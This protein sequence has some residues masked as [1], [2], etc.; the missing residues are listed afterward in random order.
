MIQFHSYLK[1]VYKV[2]TTEIVHDWISNTDD[3]R[4]ILRRLDYAYGFDIIEGN[5]TKINPNDDNPNGILR[6]LKR[7]QAR[8]NNNPEIDYFVKRVEETCETIKKLHCLFLVASYEQF[9]QDTNTFL[10]RFYSQINDPAKGQTC[11]LSGPKPFFRIRGLEHIESS[12]DKRIEFFHVPFDKRYLMGTYRYSIPGYPSL[13]CSSS[14]YCACEEFGCKDI[15]KCGY[16]AYRIAQPIRVLDLRWRFNDSKL[17]QSE[18]P[19]LVKH[20]LLRLPIIIACGMQ[21][22]VTSAKFVPEYIFSQQVFQWLMSQM[23]H[24]EKLNTTMGVLYTSTKENLWQE[25]CKRNNADAMTNYALLAFTSVTE[26]AQYSETLA[27]RL[28]ARK[29]IAWN[30]PISHKKSRFETLMDIEKELL[31]S[32]ASKYMLMSNYIYKKQ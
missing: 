4:G 8:F 31:A 25:I 6:I 18:D 26:K 24:D 32:R 12:V 23:R 11:F 17:K 1:R 3:D 9:H 13:Y 2:I 14:L 29:P 7:E 20:Y 27:S 5:P 15:D 30:K 22:K 16:S 19:T 21:V 10:H 28:E